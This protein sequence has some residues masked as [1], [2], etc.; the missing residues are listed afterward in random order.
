MLTEVAGVEEK[1]MLLKLAVDYTC[2]VPSVWDWIVLV[3]LEFAMRDFPLLQL[4]RRSNRPVAPPVGVMSGTKSALA[5]SFLRFL[6]NIW[7]SVAYFFGVLARSYE[8]KP[9]RNSKSWV[10]KSVITLRL[11]QIIVAERNGLFDNW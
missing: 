7:Q 9:K 6:S 2:H 5:F 4:L 11:Y 1:V 3:A 10:S 8:E